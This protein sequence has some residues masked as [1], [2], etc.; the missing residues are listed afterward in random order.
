MFSLCFTH[1]DTVSVKNVLNEENPSYKKH[2]KVTYSTVYIRWLKSTTNGIIFRNII[3]VSHVAGLLACFAA[4][5]TL[6]ARCYVVWHG[7]ER[8]VT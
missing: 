8:D 2:L 3:R 1:V 4:V 7:N 6:F 5:C